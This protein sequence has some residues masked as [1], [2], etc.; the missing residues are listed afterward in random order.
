VLAYHRVLARQREDLPIQDGMYV[1][2]EVFEKHLEYLK[3]HYNLISLDK[4]VSVLNGNG[5]FN[6]DCHIT[7]D[8]GWQDNFANAFPIL[9]KHGIPAT[10]FLT[11]D[12]ISTSKWFWPE[13]I[14]YLL[15]QNRLPEIEELSLLESK[16]ILSIIFLQNVSLEKRINAAIEFLKDK[17]MPT[18]GSVIEDLKIASGI[19]NFPSKRLLL[20]WDEVRE[21]GTGDITFGSHTR[22][23]A[24]LTNLDNDD[25]IAVELE[26]SK[27]EIEDQTGQEVKSFCFPNGNSN[28]K[29]IRYVKRCGYVCSFAGG[30]G[31]IDHKTDRYFLKRIGIHNDVTETIPMFACRLL[32]NF[33]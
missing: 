16:K 23:H 30:Y 2:P 29:L 10:V 3:N 11:T 18:I 27:A 14:L 4:L 24:I 1:L 32:F 19:N 7:F 13:K 26:Q 12:F 28:N 25:D 5:C 31:K 6:K 22:T 33:F 20:N 9:R 15:A 8:D 17:P 21:M